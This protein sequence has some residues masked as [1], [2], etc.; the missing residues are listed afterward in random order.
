MPLIPSP[1]ADDIGAGAPADEI[2][3]T[4][5]MIDAGAEE[6]LRWSGGAVADIGNESVAA[7]CI[8]KAMVFAARSHRKYE[9]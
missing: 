7:E 8:F 9:E 1:S 3:I 5:A 4:A 2:E 6:F